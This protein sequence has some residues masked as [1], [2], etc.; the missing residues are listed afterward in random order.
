MK[1]GFIITLTNI[2]CQLTGP[3]KL[4]VKLRNDLADKNPSAYHIRRYM[5]RG[6]DG[7]QHYLTENG[8]FHVGQLDRIVNWLMSKTD[9]P[10]SIKDT[11]DKLPECVI[12]KKIGGKVVRPYQ[13]EAVKSILHNKIGDIYHRIGVINAATNAGKTI[14][15]ALLHLSFQRKCKT[16]VLINDADLYDQF[17]T[18]IPELLGS[19]VGFVRGKEFIDGDFVIAMVPTLSRNIKQFKKFLSTFQIVAIDEADLGGSKSYR[20]VM[21]SLVHCQIRVGLSGSIYLRDTTQV[22]RF[23]NNSLRSFFGD[24]KFKISKK[25][26]VELGHSTNLIIK[27]VRGSIKKGVKGDYRNEYVKN[28]V[29]N[30]DRH[31][32]CLQR[33]KFNM[34]HGRLPAMVVCRFHEHI[35]QLYDYFIENGINPNT[36]KFVHGDSKDRKEIIKDFRDGKFEILITS[37]IVKR[38]KNFPLLRYVL[39]AAAGDSHSTVLQLMGRLERKHD[40][41]NKGYMDDLFDEGT[42]LLRHSKHRLNY[43]IKEGFKVI[44]KF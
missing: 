39:N 10:I 4:L 40:S 27:M 9:L 24:E 30:E 31:E 8:S 13:Y 41:K 38:G 43:Y 37:M 34:K 35:E 44:K 42:Y 1:E 18:E 28:I 20:N 11:R 19:G 2:R 22:D 16:I 7:K 23:K 36:I 25:E 32:V 29:D 26:M 6:W 3:A 33:L 12:P 21:M 15:M 17:K 5:P 14:M